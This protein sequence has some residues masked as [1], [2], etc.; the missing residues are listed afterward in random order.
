MQA[1]VCE[2][3]GACTV[4][5]GIPTPVDNMSRVAEQSLSLSS[6]SHPIYASHE[7]HVW[8]QV[9]NASVRFI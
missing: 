7:E 8:Q 3:F 5:A 9:I 1:A 4:R 6:S 2:V